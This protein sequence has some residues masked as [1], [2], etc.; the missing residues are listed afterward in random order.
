[1][2]AEVS[3]VGRAPSAV[4]AFQ[5]GPI[6]WLALGTFAVGTEGFMIAAILPGVASDLAV[7]LQA[8]GQLVTV[9]ALTYALSSPVTTALTGAFDRRRLLMLSMGAFA[10]ANFV[11]AFATGYWSLA[12]ARVLLA[13]AAGLYVPG[14]NALAGALVTPERR[15]RALSI[16]SGGMSLAV[17]LGVPLGAVVGTNFGWR[18]NFVGIG[19]LA[20]LALGGL[21]IGTKPGI[22][23]G[24]TAATLRERLAVIGQ[25][26]TLQVLVMTLIWA[27][28]NYVVYTFISV[29]MAEIAG[30]AGTHIAYVLFLWGASALAGTIL[31]GVATD[32]FG[33]RRVIL[34]SLPALA[35]ALASLSVSAWM[36]GAQQAVVPVLLA[37]VVW[38]FTSWAFYPAQL[39]RLIGL[40]GRRGAAVALS[41]NASFMYLGFSLGAVLGAFTLAEGGLADLGWVGGLCVLASLGLYVVTD[42]PVRA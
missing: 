29:Y 35:L 8:A 38:G 30:F 41:L 10:A 4:P 42:R 20:L 2:S 7:S 6:Y 24:L 25:R 27:L 23:A 1:M 12:G 37:V 36:L 11:A 40:A 9:F 33:S 31:G 19:V 21:I 16:V 18:T 3:A 14:A 15:G 26:A 5:Y 34:S 22:G 13:V 28:G 17:A 39:A 32:R